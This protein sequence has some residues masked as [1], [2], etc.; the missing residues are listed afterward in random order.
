MSLARLLRGRGAR[1][2]ARVVLADTYGWFT[3]GS[4]TRDLRMARSL[5]AEK[6]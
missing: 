3:E 2:E 5:L 6:G 4:E 1:E